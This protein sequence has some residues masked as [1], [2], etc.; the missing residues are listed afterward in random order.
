MSP[1]VCLQGPIYFVTKI[2]RCRF[3]GLRPDSTKVETRRDL[4]PY[5][6][7]LELSHIHILYTLFNCIDA[8][9]V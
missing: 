4:F 2:H 1:Q 5:K 9:Q 6:L 7:Q 8:E 3:S